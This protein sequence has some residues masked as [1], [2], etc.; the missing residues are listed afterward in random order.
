MAVFKYCHNAKNSV[1]LKYD[2]SNIAI[3][4]PFLG[5]TVFKSAIIKKV[6]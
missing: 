4:E 3:L 5:M 2:N 1:I 6:L